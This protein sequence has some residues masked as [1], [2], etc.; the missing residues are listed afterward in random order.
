MG[1]PSVLASLLP[2]FLI[3]I[4]GY[5]LKKSKFPGDNFWPGAEQIVYYILFPALLFSSSAG[6]S[7]EFFSVASMVWAILATMFVMS[8]LLLLLRPRLTKKDA[9]F[10]SI[11]QGSIRFTSYIGLAAAFSLFGDEGLYLAAVLITVLIPLVNVLSVM[12]LVRYGGQKGGWYWIFTTVIK[13]PLIIA[14]LAGMLVNLLGWQL[15]S[16]VENMTTI[17]GRG[18][19]PLGL[20]AVGSSL[21]FSSIKKTGLEIVYACLLKLILLP[22]LMWLTCT[23]LG[24]DNLSTAIAVLFA[25]LP[26]S[27]LSYVLA[28]QL[29]GDTKLM[30]SIIAV[31]TGVSMI[32]LPVIIALVT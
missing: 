4:C 7:W 5:G 6:A 29:G 14:C 20:L 3:I 25:A 28:K 30:S 32:S 26:G 1:T 24:V 21:D 17:L 10:T 15:P 13:N 19:L 12:V 2:V 23:L 16:M 8:G 11:F 9:S 31:Q 18:S 27:P 22:L